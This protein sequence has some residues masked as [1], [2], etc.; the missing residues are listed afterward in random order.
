MRSKTRVRPAF[1]GRQMVDVQCPRCRARLAQLWSIA[2]ATG[3][4]WD[5]TIYAHTEKH[6]ARWLER[7]WTCQRCRWHAA[8]DVGVAELVQWAEQNRQRTVTFGQPVPV[9]R[10]RDW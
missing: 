7:S 5:G 1:R 3:L 4:D 6:A 8:D 10:S 2:K 9:N